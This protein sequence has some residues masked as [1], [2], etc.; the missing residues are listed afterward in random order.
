MDMK[1]DVINMV[2]SI[3]NETVLNYI[4]IVIE[5]AIEDIEADKHKEE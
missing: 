1:Q 2:N 3:E 5:E 4:R